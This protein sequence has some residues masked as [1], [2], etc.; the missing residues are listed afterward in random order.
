MWGVM[1]SVD[2]PRYM[3]VILL[4]CISTAVYMV[5]DHFPVVLVALTLIPYGFYAIIFSMTLGFKMHNAVLG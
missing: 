1:V 5:L 4:S 2:K 3:F